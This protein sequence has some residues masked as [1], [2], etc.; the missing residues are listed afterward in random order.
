M[1]T[2]KNLLALSLLVS[3]LL[4]SN[5]SNATDA[6]LP[7]E[8]SKAFDIIQRYSSSSQSICSMDQSSLNDILNNSEIAFSRNSLLERSIADNTVTIAGE[9]HLYTDLNGRLDLIRLFQKL[10]GATAC[11]AFELPKNSEGLSGVINKLTKMTDEDR[12]IGGKNLV[13]AE[14]IDRIVFYY[15]PMGDLVTNLGLKD[16]TVD[17]S[18]NLDKDHSMD[19]RNKAMSDNIS[20]LVRNGDCTDILMFVGKNHM[21]VGN[22]S[23]T[24]LP[25]LIKQNGIHTVSV[26]IQMTNE[27]VIPSTYRTWDGCKA[28]AINNDI[29]FKSLKLPKDVKLFPSSSESTTWSDFDFTLLLP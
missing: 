24:K 23:T 12:K 19:E 25:E 29:F 10:K 21:A 18:D 1:K 28:P 9:M 5:Y 17:F 22:D 4:D 13:R 3:L 6:S 16:F 27:E 20:A 2:I 8:V 15:K 7:P 26:N 14:N 11:V